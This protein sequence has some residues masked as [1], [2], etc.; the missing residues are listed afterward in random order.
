M[1]LY[2]GEEVHLR[3]MH[4]HITLIGVIVGSLEIS[5]NGL[6]SEK[7]SDSLPC[8]SYDSVGN[9][10]MC[11]KNEET[12]LQYLILILIKTLT[13]YVYSKKT[14]KQTSVG[15]PFALMLVS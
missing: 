15:G 5:W 13:K 4:G 8:S 12:S 6:S 1:L 10:Y 11:C 2:L 7:G 9:N 3:P 14:P